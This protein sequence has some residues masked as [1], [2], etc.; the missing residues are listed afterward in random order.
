MVKRWQTIQKPHFLSG[1]QMVLTKWLPF[2]IRKPD[3]KSVLKMTIQ[4]PDGLVFGGSLYY[5]FTWGPV[6]KTV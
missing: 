2:T 4:I 3:L 6:L 5:T 1:F